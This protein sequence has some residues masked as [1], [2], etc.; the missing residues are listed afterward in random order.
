MLEHDIILTQTL[1]ALKRQ[2]SLNLAQNQRFP[3]FRAI[4]SAILCIYVS[5]I[6][7][8]AFHCPIT[9]LHCSESLVLMNRPHG[10]FLFHQLLTKK[11][12]LFYFTIEFS[13]VGTRLMVDVVV[14]YDTQ[15]TPRHMHLTRTPLPA[16]RL[17][18]PASPES[19]HYSTI[20]MY[21]CTHSSMGPLF[22]R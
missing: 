20:A 6:G 2:K 4:F 15:N 3:I 13:L 18:A 22:L 7:N 8:V 14:S 1:M 17:W 19:T 10:D 16:S 21:K 5:K 12:P 11:G 9:A